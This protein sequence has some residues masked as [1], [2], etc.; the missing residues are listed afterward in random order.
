MTQRANAV[1][2]WLGMLLKEGFAVSGPGAYLPDPTEGI[3]RRKNCRRPRSFGHANF[4][5]STVRTA[6]NAV[7]ATVSF[8]ARP[9]R[10][11]GLGLQPTGVTSALVYSHINCTRCR[12]YFT[13][14]TSEYALAN[15]ATRIVSFR[16]RASHR[17]GTAALSSRQF[18]TCPP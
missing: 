13:A 8:T 18:G 14:D 3:T 9:S 12:R 4:K 17:R 15:A 11:G 2:S 6:A 5:H 10:R 1:H 7:R 16:W